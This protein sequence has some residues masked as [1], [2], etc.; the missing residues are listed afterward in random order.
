M[1][2]AVV[3]PSFM[4]AAAYITT[5][6]PQN[7]GHYE[8]LIGGKRHTIQLKKVGLL[9]HGDECHDLRHR[10]LNGRATTLAWV[11]QEHLRRR[12]LLVGGVVITGGL[13]DRGFEQSVPEEFE[14]IFTHTGW[15]KL[16]VQNF[17]GDWEDYL[18]KYADWYVAM[19]AALNCIDTW[20][21][22][23]DARVEPHFGEVK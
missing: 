2:R 20:E 3:I 8:R 7:V 6:D 10:P 11:Y 5:L 21:L 16:R 15:F 17:H 18:Y 23:K 14:R 12:A 9:L 1:I 22:Y 13:D 19:I 4:D